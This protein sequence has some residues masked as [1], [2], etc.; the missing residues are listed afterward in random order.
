MEKGAKIKSIDISDSMKKGAIPE[1]HLYQPI[2]WK[3]IANSTNT[4]RMQFSVALYLRIRIGI[5]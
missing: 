3:L 2:E 4:N 5:N 1:E